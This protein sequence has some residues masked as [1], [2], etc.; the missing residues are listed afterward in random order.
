MAE[1]GSRRV[2][3][4]KAFTKA[5]NAAINKVSG[6]PMQYFPKDIS[7]PDKAAIK[8]Y[9]DNMLSTV[10]KNI[11]SEFD[12]I[13]EER[14]MTTKLNSLDALIAEQP[15]LSDGTRITPEFF[16]LAADEIVRNRSVQRKTK[17]KARLTAH[18]ADLEAETARLK[19]ELEPRR[20]QVTVLVGE[21]KERQ[22]QVD[23]ALQASQPQ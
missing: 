19:T 10:V 22:A 1:Q 4:Q 12:L 18:L 7:S 17:E 2:Q 20:A 23:L 21:L 3:L 9:W 13:C 8:A 14:H 16:Q 6:D 15:V 11:E 5:L